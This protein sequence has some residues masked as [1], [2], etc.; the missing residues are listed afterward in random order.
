MLLM[1]CG[2]PCE[3]SVPSFSKIM[4]GCC[5]KIESRTC[6]WKHSDSSQRRQIKQPQS[7]RYVFALLGFKTKSKYSAKLYTMKKDFN[8][9]LTIMFSG[10]AMALRTLAQILDFQAHTAHS[11]LKRPLLKTAH[12][13]IFV[14]LISRNIYSEENRRH[15]YAN[16]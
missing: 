4:P 13:F 12:L 7:E 5:Q 11:T 16:F 2:T 8:A 15:H 10:Q 14:C 9:Y 3:V 1:S 6:E